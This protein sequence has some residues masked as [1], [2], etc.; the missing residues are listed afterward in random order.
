MTQTPP[1]NLV[2]QSLAAGAGFIRERI[3]LVVLIY[4]VDLVIALLLALPLY[5]AFVEQVG[6]SGFGADLMM[7]FDLILWR[8]VIDLV[9]DAFVS[10]GLQLL[11]V[12]PV[13]ML[14][15]TAAHMGVI[16]ALHQGALW[17]FWR[18]VGYYTGKGLLIGFIFAPLKGMVLGIVGVL[19]SALFMVWPGEVGGFWIFAVFAPTMLISLL[20]M[21][22]LFQRYARISIVVRHDTLGRALKAGFTWPIKYGAASY[23]Y[24]VWFFLSLAVFLITTGLNAALHVGVTAVILGF[25]LQQISLFTR[26]AVM[27]G[28]VGSEVSLFERTH[29]SELPLIADA[30]EWPEAPEQPD[31]LTF[32]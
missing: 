19:A 2:S 24:L 12:I 21:V 31:G 11:I 8:D 18:G 7:G 17:P 16:Y 1:E 10:L 27:V 14:W 25:V 30:V 32:T 15:K 23:L 20:A 22:D 28:W 9:S 5:N 26:T 3:G 4:V 13:Y 29:L 6:I